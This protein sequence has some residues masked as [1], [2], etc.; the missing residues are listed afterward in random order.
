MHNSI[1]ENSDSRNIECR[2]V[3]VYCPLIRQIMETDETAVPLL[4]ELW[5]LDTFVIAP[6][7]DDIGHQVRLQFSDRSDVEEFLW[8]ICRAIDNI[9]GAPSNLRERM[10]GMHPDQNA[11]GDQLNWTYDAEVYDL[12]EDSDAKKTSEKL[13]PFNILVAID[14]SF[15]RSDFDFVLQ[16]IKNEVDARH[17][18]KLI[19][20]RA[21]KA[22]EKNHV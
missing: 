20:E 10:F 5:A 11:S 16:A 8:H 9:D 1:N 7:V 17:N 3:K 22:S 21:T 4:K 12:S 2:Q 14:V 6:C 18:R 13:W 19:N 15:P